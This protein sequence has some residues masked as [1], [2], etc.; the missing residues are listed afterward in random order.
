MSSLTHVQI[1]PVDQ[2]GWVARL[3]WVCVCVTAVRLLLVHLCLL[4]SCS[5]SWASRKVQPGSPHLFRDGPVPA[6]CF[7]SSPEGTFCARGYRMVE[8]ESR[9]WST[10]TLFCVVMDWS[11]VEHLCSQMLLDFVGQTSEQ[12]YPSRR[13]GLLRPRLRPDWW[14]QQTSQLCLHS[15][16]LVHV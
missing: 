14:R 5:S 6:S 10:C 8:S 12:L 3:L 16:E 1:S 9:Y 13:P 4:R 15:A 7:L 2:P 11:H